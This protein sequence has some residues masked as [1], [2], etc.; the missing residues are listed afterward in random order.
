MIVNLDNHG[1][2]TQCSLSPGRKI[3]ILLSVQQSLRNDARFSLLI[4]KIHLHHIFFRT[5]EIFFPESGFITDITTHNSS[6]GRS[7]NLF[8]CYRIHYTFKYWTLLHYPYYSFFICNLYYY[9]EA[10]RWS[11]ETIELWFIW[12]DLFFWLLWKLVWFQINNVPW[13]DQTWYHFQF[14]VWF[15]FYFWLSSIELLLSPLPRLSGSAWQ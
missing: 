9:S 14:S 10:E 3:D 7:I 2:D 5:K 15:H 13:A 1:D 8:R 6:R 12:F 11:N 4:E